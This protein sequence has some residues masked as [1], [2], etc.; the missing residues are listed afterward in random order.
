MR[1]YLVEFIGTFFLFFT[2]CMSVH[3]GLGNLAPLVIG[4]MLTA[5]IYA[6]GHIS[7]AHYNPAATLTLYLRGKCPLSDVPGYLLAELLGAITAAGAGRYL[8][9]ADGKTLPLASSV[10]TVPA[11]LAETLGTFAICFVILN[12]ATATGTEGN[13][14]YGIAIGLTVVGCAYALGSISGGAFNFAV[15]LGLVMTGTLLWSQLWLYLLANI[16]AATLAA[17]AFAYIS[18]PPTGLVEVGS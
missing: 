12:V 8:L 14:S 16:V 2:I 7:G 15:A 18:T 6:G 11:L 13:D 5:M 10:P 1:K 3:G 4:A 17:A 9:A